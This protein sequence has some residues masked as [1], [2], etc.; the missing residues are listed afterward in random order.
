M[1]RSL[2]WRGILILL[3]IAGA[4]AAAYP[5][6]KK[7]N[8]GLD[9]RGGMHLVLEVKTDDALS[10]ETQREMSTLVDQLK[11][12]GLAAVKAQALDPSSFSVSPID[13]EQESILAKAAKDFLPKWQWSR[14]G[15]TAV[16]KMQEDDVREV[17]DL[18]VRQAQQTIW[19]RVDAYGVAEPV[20]QRLGLSGDRIVVQLPGVDDPER[21]R[22]LIK[23]TA[24]LEFRLVDYPKTGSG[25]ASEQDL[26]AHYGGTLPDD[27]EVM[28]HD[29]KDRE[30]RVTGKDYYAVQKKQVITGRELKTARASL[31]QL[32]QPIVTFS[33]TP[34]GGKRFGEI[35][36][37]NVGEFLAIVLDGKVVSAPRLNSRIADQGQIEG[38]FT[39]EQVED[40]AH[41]AALRRP[42]GA[43]TYL[44]ERTVGPSLG[45]RLDP[46][47]R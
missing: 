2:M 21:I 19:N 31:D 45:R 8:L 34:E 30:G 36:G 40:L 10:A 12:A 37:A 14:D 13:A 9:L 35:T 32:Q 25:A 20:V 26:L 43:L 17:R 41:D 18:A 16:F 3:I 11:E 5:L 29:E 28:A 46:A 22:R 4:L 38:S 6:D 27:V 44:E 42:A 39:Q 7:I 47:G 1:N 23:N 24:F 15:D 33:L